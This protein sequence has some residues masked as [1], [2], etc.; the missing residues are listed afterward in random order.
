M[1]TKPKASKLHTP[2]GIAAYVQLHTP[3]QRTDR[4]GQ[5]QGEPKYGLAL[6]FPEDTDLDEMIGVAEAK[7]R[8]AFGPKWEDMKNKGKINW[9]FQDT[10][11]IDEPSPPFDQPGTVVNFKTAEKPGIVDADAEPVMDKSDVYS[12]M[13]AR[14]S[15]RCFSYDNES[16]GVS[17]ALINV[18]KLDDGERMSGNPSAEDDFGGS[19]TK[20]SKTKTRP[21]MRKRN[22][23]IDDLL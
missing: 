1:A 5:P 13:K 21:G 14:V 11:D 7:A 16:K 20:P 10:A 12:G 3:K 15:T 9:P 19:K 6:F 18:Q 8:E 22:E 23:D 4:K 2:E 17:F